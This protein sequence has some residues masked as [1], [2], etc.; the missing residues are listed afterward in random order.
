MED[1]IVV[2]GQLRIWVESI[3]K[4]A[5]NK[6]VANLVQ[7]CAVEELGNLLFLDGSRCSPPPSLAS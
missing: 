5:A 6:L 7:L 1:L 4:A 3:L 2:A